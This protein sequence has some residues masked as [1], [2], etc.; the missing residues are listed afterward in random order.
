[1]A[2]IERKSAILA[3]KALKNDRILAPFGAKIIVYD[4]FW[5][6]GQNTDKLLI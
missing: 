3:P 1:M 4:H 2:Y 5:P 6:F